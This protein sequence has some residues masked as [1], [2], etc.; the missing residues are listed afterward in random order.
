MDRH[1]ASKTGVLGLVGAGVAL[2]FL[3]GV[4]TRTDF[5]TGAF[6]VTGLVILVGT[7]RLSAQRRS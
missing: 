5:L 1:K 4:V 7:I 2:S 6:I 3:F